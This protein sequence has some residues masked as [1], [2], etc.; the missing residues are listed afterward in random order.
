MLILSYLQV[1]LA[2]LAEA[3]VECNEKLQVI[4][5]SCSAME[6]A[7]SVDGSRPRIPVKVSQWNPIKIYLGTHNIVTL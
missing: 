7:A 1:G 2:S 4:K 6:N 5:K 3:Q